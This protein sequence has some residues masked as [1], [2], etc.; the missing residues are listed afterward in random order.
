MIRSI[1]A[2]T[3]EI[4]YKKT[5]E[6]LLIIQEVLKTDCVYF[7]ET[8]IS[9]VDLTQGFVPIKLRKPLNEVLKLAAALTS[10]GTS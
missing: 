3:Q 2:T 6:T 1:L 8:F 7:I 10:Y 5:P 4:S 9:K